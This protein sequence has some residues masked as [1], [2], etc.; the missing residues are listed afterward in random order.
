MKRGRL[1]HELLRRFGASPEN[2][3]RLDELDNAAPRLF[4]T[5][6][7]SHYLLCARRDTASACDS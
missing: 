3:M 5:R 1:S 6:R 7:Q 2:S 4:R